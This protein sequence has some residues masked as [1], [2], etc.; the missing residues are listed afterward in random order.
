MRDVELGSPDTETEMMP[1]TIETGTEM[2]LET[3]VET[4]LEAE[5]VVENELASPQPIV[6][7]I[8]PEIYGTL[9]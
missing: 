4:T 8:E 9:L 1:T 7:Q 3:N 6:C 2:D 5:I